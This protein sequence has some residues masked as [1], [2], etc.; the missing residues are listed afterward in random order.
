MSAAVTLIVGADRQEFST[1]KSYEVESSLL[2]PANAFH[3][4]LANVD[5]ELAG[6]IGK[7]DPVQI[8]IDGQPIMVG[9]VDDVEYDG[10]DGGDV[11]Q[12]TGRDLFGYL[13]DC[14]AP[15]QIYREQT[16][17]QV[18]EKMCSPAWGITWQVATGTTLRRRTSAKIV[19]DED[20]FLG[21]TLE[22]HQQRTKV[23]PGE[24]VAEVLQRL[25]DKESVLIWL[26]RDGTALIGKPNYDQAPRYQIY[27]YLNAN[28]LAKTHNNTLSAQV[29]ESW[30]EQ[31]STITVHGTS[32]NTAVN[33]GKSSR[34]R[35]V[36][37]EID[38]DD[39]DLIL[40]SGDCRTLAQ[41]QARADKE[42]GRRAFE[43]LALSYTMNGHY[44][45]RDGGEALWECNTIAEVVDEYSDQQG[46]FYVSRV[47]YTG[48]ENGQRTSVELH[49]P[50]V[51]L[52]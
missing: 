25:G 1:W 35:A 9:R 39:R 17:L 44:G 7:G 15:L 32:G 47:R 48:D 40:V 31:Y 4:N 37:T 28:P 46:R 36:A 45:V 33:Y 52:T 11:V 22:R 16:L 6:V 13:V 30:R 43:A 20:T 38:I 21:V 5:G 19:E 2:E 27:R 42:K 50:G 18:A 14:A 24:R 12:I 26:T 34:R 8:L 10:D 23:E 3:F 51:W 41:A 29:R 49:P